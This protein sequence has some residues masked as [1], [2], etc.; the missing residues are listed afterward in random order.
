MSL[1]STTMNDST[2]L[3]RNKALVLL[4]RA[5][6]I[7]AVLFFIAWIVDQHVPIAGI[8]TIHYTSGVPNGSVTRPHPLDRVVT[9]DLAKV[10][11]F[12]EDPVYFEVKTS[13][14]YDHV[15]LSFRYKNKLAVPLRVGVKRSDRENDILFSEVEEEKK[16]GDWT[17]ATTA[18][19][20]SSVRRMNHRYH[21]LFSMPGL[22]YEYPE[23][24]SL[25]LSRMTVRLVR[26]P[27]IHL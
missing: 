15:E 20:L 5:I 2:K 23:K 22:Q 21:F 17:I 10:E 26:L 18:F 1:S 7:A 3:K 11:T 8:R 9:D 27:L 25:T 13:V 14:P 24:G 4:H 12:I 6:I 16:D 19:D